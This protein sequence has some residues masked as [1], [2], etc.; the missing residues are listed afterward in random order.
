LLNFWGHVVHRYRWL[1][2]AA[3][4]VLLIG[5]VAV[6]LTGGR[7]QSADIPVT[8]ESGRAVA[9]MDREL[10]GQ[11]PTFSLI[12]TS[13]TL[14]ATD[15]RFRSAVEKALAPL[16]RDGRIAAIRTAYAT[17]AADLISRDGHATV[18]I[19]EL[20]G[21]AA[22]FASIETSPPAGSDVYPE[23]RRQVRSD[24]LEVLPAGPLALSYDFKT[25]VQHDLRHAEIV[26]LPVVLACLLFVFGAPVAAAL[27]IAVGLFAVAGGLAGTFLLSRVTSVSVYA[28]N[29][30]TMIG[31]GV[32]IDYS[33]FVV[34]RFREEI[35]EHGTAESLART[36]NTAGRV[37]VFS[38]STVAIGLL[39][40][41]WMPVGGIGSMGVAGTIVVASAVFYGL[42]LLLAVLAVLGRRIDVWS[43]PSLDRDQ[44]PAERNLWHR[45]AT[46]VMRH[47][48]AVLLPVTAVLLLLGSPVAHMDLATEEARSLPASAESRRG[49]ELLRTQ[50]PGRDLT[51]VMVVVHY[52]DGSPWTA[53][54]LGDFHDLSQRLRRLAGVT[55]IDSVV[56]LDPRV[57][58]EQ[59]QRLATAPPTALPPGL[60]FLRDQTVG[61][62]IATLVVSTAHAADSPETRALVKSIR[63]LSAPPGSELLVTGATAF[64]LDFIGVVTHYGP[65]AIACVLVATYLVVFALLGSVFLP[66]KAVVMNLLSITASYGA[67]VWIFQDGYLARWLDFTP[68][69]IQPALPLI[70][71][72][73]LFGLSMDYEV[74]LLSRTREEYRRTRDNT[75]AVA[76]SLERTGRLITG[77]AAIMAAVFFGFGLSST[78]IVK[79]MGIGMGIA[80]IVDATIVRAVLVPATMELLGRWN[81]WSPRVL[82]RLRRRLGLAEPPAA[83]PTRRAGVRERAA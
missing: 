11:H 36:T 8:L 69:P 40:L 70:M 83:P 52:A 27:P 81:W 49:E 51:Q 10:P 74:L 21:R 39:A 58:R 53:E 7:F 59:Y 45:V 66:V 19:V 65:I 14:R 61:A 38:G 42:T 78:V 76:A 4:V 15:P 18:A 23:L 24:E 50:F 79:T 22:A 57:T 63:R 80:V 28:T 34:S 17:P 31:L 5:S 9:L 29:I 16:H 12:F 30:V 1:V 71:F 56:D 13:G 67:L 3:C 25:V 48:W 20:H 32:A 75:R 37:I 64:D 33:L 35:R 55:R 41:L 26:V 43:L 72:C 73:V 6:I 2:L 82:Q 62:H 77:A 60:R 46:L 68:G 44:S 54:R 47:P